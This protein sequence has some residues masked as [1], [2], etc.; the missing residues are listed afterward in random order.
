MEAGKD[1]GIM[2]CGLGA[3][4]TLRL[5]AGMPLYGH[6]MDET[7]T[8]LEARAWYVRKAWEKGLYRKRS[9]RGIRSVKRKR[10]G[11][12]VVGRGIVREQ[13]P[14]F[15]G[16]TQV[17]FSTSGTHCPFLGYAAAMG[18]V[19]IPFSEPGTLLEAEVRGRR[20]AVEVTALPFYK[21]KKG[22]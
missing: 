16:D 9:H 14:L 7:I 20:I 21:K 1:D 12:K 4:D 15:N 11:M 6:E 5:E 2:A 18:I 10:V 17:G 8:P 22:G 19:D 3:R 13:A